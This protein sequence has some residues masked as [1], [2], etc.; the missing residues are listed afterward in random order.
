MASLSYN[1]DFKD[2]KYLTSNYSSENSKYIVNR[3]KED[4]PMIKIKVDKNY[5]VD[6]KEEAPKN[7]SR[8]VFS[9]IPQGTSKIFRRLI[10]KTLDLTFDK[11]MY[12]YFGV[13]LIIL[14]LSIKLFNKIE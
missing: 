6:D 11:E 4:E 13:L 7:S 1:F 14:S 2:T 8:I 12:I 10:S 5:K 9:D 3:Q